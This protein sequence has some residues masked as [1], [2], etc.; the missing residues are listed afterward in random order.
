MEKGTITR[1]WKS[2]F[3]AEYYFL[4]KG[5]TLRP[6]FLKRGG[7]QKGELTKIFKK[8]DLLKRRG[9]LKRGD[10]DPLTTYDCPPTLAQGSDPSFYS[11]S[12]LFGIPPRHPF[13]KK[14][15]FAIYQAWYTR[16]ATRCMFAWFKEGSNPSFF[17][18]SPWKSLNTPLF[19]SDYTWSI[20]PLRCQKGLNSGRGLSPP[21]IFD[22]PFWVSPLKNQNLRSPL[23]PFSG[24][25]IPL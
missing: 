23:R 13:L 24:K 3:R 18:I 11:W 22:P 19:S 14:N 5:G 17:C 15:F 2:A 16:K 8:E 10:W 21:F 6:K 20:E 7:S 12:P 1:I 9:S 25:L 4:S